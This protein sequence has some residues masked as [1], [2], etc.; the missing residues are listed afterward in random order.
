MLCESPVLQQSLHVEVFYPYGLVFA[1]EGCSEDMKGVRAEVGDPFVGSCKLS[2]C[3]VS[4]LGTFLF[5][6]QLSLETT[7]LPLCL[8]IIT[9]VRKRLTCRKR[10]EISQS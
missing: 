6:S 2:S 1:Y 5:P 9:R 3:F 4:V 8:K 10:G 7:K